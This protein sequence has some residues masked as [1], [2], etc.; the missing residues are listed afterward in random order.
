MRTFSKI[1][2]VGWAI[3]AYNTYG[4]VKEF[5]SFLWLLIKVVAGKN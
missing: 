4:T 1:K 3:G 2:K 5:P